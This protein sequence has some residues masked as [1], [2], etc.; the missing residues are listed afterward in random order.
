MCALVIS[1]SLCFGCGRDP[2][3]ATTPHTH[4]GSENGSAAEA[5]ARNCDFSQYQPVRIS[6][7]LWHGGI[8]TRVEPTYPSEAKQHRLQGRI[9]VSVV[10]DGDGHVVQA[11][12]DGHPILRDAAEGAAQKWRFR[13]PVLNGEKIPYIHEI[14][15]FDFVLETKL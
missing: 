11:C 14:L 6:D 15:Q 3:E 12:G 7:W 13:P 4:A 9:S 5:G 1:L 10:I 8:V 2:A